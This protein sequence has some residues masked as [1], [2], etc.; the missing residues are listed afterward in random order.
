VVAQFLES[1]G[2]SQRASRIHVLLLS[3]LLLI[4]VMVVEWFQKLD[5]SLGVLYVLPVVLAATV[6][7]L[8]QT[9]LIAIMC[10]C[11]RSLFISS[12]LSPIEFSLRF[13]MAVLAYGGVGGLVSTMSRNRRAILAAYA[14]LRMEENLRRNAED[15]LR[16]LV[17][18]SPAAIMTLNQTAEVLA[19]NRAAHQFLGFGE[20]GSLV[21]KSIAEYVPVFAGAL[22]VSPGGPMRVASSSWATRADGSHFP[23][24]VWFSTYEDA[25][26]LRLAGI[27]VDTSED[28]RERERETFRHLTDSTRLLA[29]AVAHEIRNLCSAIRVVTSNLRRYPDI[30]LDADYGALNTLVESL[31]RIA[32]FELASG[33]DQQAARVDVAAV[34][35]ELRL[36][37]EPDWQDIGG[38]IDWDIQGV[39]PYFHADEHSLLQVFLN[40]SQNSLRAVQRGG[41]PHLRIRVT[42]DNGQAKV[43]FEDSGP[44]IEDT[45][46]LFQPF[47]ENADG[48]GL[49][50]YV[51]RAMLRGF[52]GEL[53][54]VPTPSGCR[55]DVTLPTYPV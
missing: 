23:V 36:V 11:A 8:W 45:N 29:G 31:M 37:I 21:G 17:E 2:V 40:L 5:Y 3:F 24:A 39:L 26:N 9:L 16:I 30:V 44:G 34:L 53:T 48:S 25:G 4:A 42:G 19:A 50:L 33:K 41:E 46:R 12:G 27:L 10:A 43:I 54:H 18:S 28:V 47:R 32:A 38:S 51:S 35:E 55:F 49:G 22:R 1:L 15:Q 52:G 7:N 13:L 14:R 20:P 6:L